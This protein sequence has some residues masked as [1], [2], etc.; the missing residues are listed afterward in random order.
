MGVC[1]GVTQGGVIT[2]EL[3]VGGGAQRR[4]FCLEMV[5]A[6]LASVD[7]RKI[8]YGEAPRVLVEAQTRACDNKV[9][10][11]STFQ[12]QQP[13]TAKAAVKAK[14]E[15]AKIQLSDIRSGTHFY[16]N[17]VGNKAAD[18]IEESMK[19]FTKE[20][21]TKGAPVDLKVGKNVAA[22][23]N[24]GSGKSWYRAKILEK[25][26]GKA[27]VLFIDHGNVATVKISTDL[28]PLD[29]EL[30]SDRI[31]AI[32]KEAVLAL[33][34]A[35]SLDEDDGVDA[36]RYLQKIAW[37]KELTARIFCESEGKLAVSLYIEDNPSSI[38]EQMIREGLARP[39]K[40]V[41]AD[42]LST[43]M[44][45]NENLTILSREL[46]GAE[47]AARKARRGLWRYGDVGDDDEAE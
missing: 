30:S 38:N 20:H 14:E 23:F 11:W 13:V 31:P 3:F 25:K 10:L 17:V 26:I 1:K 16:F 9:G 41:E 44:L 6:G 35:R 18:V 33:T 5:G 7:Q 45:R 42:K 8:E 19:I 34:K 43:S 28:R 24:D 40:K 37:G 21:G 15:M 39:L 2:G 36:A 22:L 32:A 12:K 4:N 27:K 46:Q 47:T 29:T